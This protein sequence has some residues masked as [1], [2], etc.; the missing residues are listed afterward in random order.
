MP[1]NNRKQGR[2]SDLVRSESFNIEHVDAFILNPNSS[3][4]LVQRLYT[5]PAWKIT[6]EAPSLVIFVHS[7]TE[8]LNRKDGEP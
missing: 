3:H 6:C 4:T 8:C 7:A 1:N 5:N 2:H